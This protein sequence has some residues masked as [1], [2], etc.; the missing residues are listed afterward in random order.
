LPGPRSTVTLKEHVLVKC[1][2]HDSLTLGTTET[3]QIELKSYNVTLPMATLAIGV[4]NIHHD[5][6]L[7]PR[8]VHACREYLFELIRQSTSATYFSGIE[9]RASKGM[10]NAAFRKMLTDLLQSAVTQAKYNKISKL[11][12]CFG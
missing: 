9:L 2:A 7:S 4:D 8:F 1:M 10:D 5:V 12:C 3:S 11:T 6:L